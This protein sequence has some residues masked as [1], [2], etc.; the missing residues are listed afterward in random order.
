MRIALCQINSTVGDFDGNLSLIRNALKKSDNAELVV[1]PELCLCG[2]VPSDLLLIQDFRQ[3]CM[4]ALNTLAKEITTQKVVVGFAEWNNGSL[5]NSAALLGDGKVLA[6]QRKI[7]QQNF[8]VYADARH[9]EAAK[10]EDATPV[11]VNGVKVGLT[12]GED[13]ES[14]VVEK[15]HKDGAQLL[16][17][18]NASSYC[19]DESEARIEA[20][21]EQ[22]KRSQMPLFCCN[23]VGANDSIIFEGRSVAIDAQGNLIAVAKAFEEDVLVHNSDEI[24]QAEFETETM[25]DV[26]EALALGIRDYC[27]KTGINSVLLG[28]SGGIDSAVVAA[29]AVKALGKENVTGIGLPSRYSSEGSVTDA[30]DLA[31]NLGIRF[32]IVP[33]EGPFAAC[34]TA[35]NPLFAGTQENVTEENIQSRLRGLILMAFSNKFGGM[36]LATGNKSECSVGYCTLYGDTC[37]GMEVISDLW[38]TEV[39]EL[40]HY[41]NRNGEIIPNSTLTKA[42]SAELRPNQCDQDSLPPYDVLDCIL[43]QYVVFGRSRDDITAAGK[44]GEITYDEATV[45]RVCKLV[46]LNEYKRAQVAL[47][48]K[49]THRAFG[50]G[51]QLPIVQRFRKNW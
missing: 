29:L 13:I 14:D 26:E 36:V 23:A 16:I 32:E 27:K 1:F 49:L 2:A 24:G 10:L 8:D 28:L 38:K 41:I 15:L 20:L 44:T 30:R 34:L 37:G 7:L 50:S 11:L 19:M 46:D 18:V 12:I 5:Y 21:Q 9:F 51:R 22:A 47:G 39:Y 43:E 3:S 42:P 4:D 48:L 6:V 17:N 33:I 45:R 40:A 35:L 31:K 25:A